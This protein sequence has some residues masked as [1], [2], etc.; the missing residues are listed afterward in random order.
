M[1]EPQL[2]QA[3]EKNPLFVIGEQKV[4]SFEE[5]AAKLFNTPLLANDARAKIF[6]RLFENRL[7]NTGFTTVVVP[8]MPQASVLSFEGGSG[9]RKP[10]QMKGNGVA[11]IEIAGALVNRYGWLEGCGMTSYD[12]LRAQL[13]FA[14]NDN[15]VKAVVLQIESPGGECGGAFDIAEYV[16]QFRKAKPIYAVAND[17]AY[18]AGYLLFSQ[19]TKG[20]VTN[21]SGVGSIGVI[22]QL[23]D[24]T[25]FD[26]QMG[27]QYKIVRA[28]AKKQQ[29]NPH[30]P[31]TEETVADLRVEMDRLYGLF[32]SAVARGR[33]M[34]E[35]AVRGTEAAPVFG[36]AAVELGLA[37]GIASIHDVLAMIGDGRLA[38]SSA[39]TGYMESGTVSAESIKAGTIT[40]TPGPIHLYA[41]GKLIGVLDDGPMS[42]LLRAVAPKSKS[43]DPPTAGP[44]DIPAKPGED[45]EDMEEPEVEEEIPSPAATVEEENP[46]EKTPMEENT[47]PTAAEAAAK[48]K[49]D[50]IAE[51]AAETEMK[52][53]LCKLA[54]APFEAEYAKMSVADLQAKL[55]KMRAEAEPSI[56]SAP[57]RS[58]G[59]SALE[60]IAA[61]AKTRAAAGGTTF[62]KEYVRL[63][64]ANP[65]AY[66]AYDRAHMAAHK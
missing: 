61:E 49:A 8:Q 20:F 50:A 57:G 40:A 7:K 47:N 14:K 16:Y 48:A 46:K 21:T 17:Y 51:L 34:S 22:A 52:V 18:S 63:L 59:F 60:T 53:N 30:E 28:G 15:D 45:P 13:E 58:A 31:I 41:D 29:G 5:A 6:T 66:A 32:V 33:K 24:M 3:D 37:D 42:D 39:S 54:G 36:P 55:L 19:C 10:Y 12:Y 44:G 64:N 25:K 1:T 11:V 65:A 27:L 23:I 4:V 9:G 56:Q 43:E 62:E 38:S 2:N 26:A 35:A